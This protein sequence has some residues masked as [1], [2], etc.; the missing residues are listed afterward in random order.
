MGNQQIFKKKIM[1][2]SVP[3]CSINPPTFHG[4]RD[5]SWG[6]QELLDYSFKV[7]I[8]YHAA[9]VNFF[10]QASSLLHLYRSHGVNELARG[11]DADGEEIAVVARREG[12]KPVND[13]LL[14]LHDL[15]VDF[16]NEDRQYE[17]HF[18]S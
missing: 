18:G 2:T 12:G 17:L 15:F 8:D 10:R 6:L 7:L 11:V 9:V 1:I 5:F 16:L 3:S 13:N 14:A 4:L